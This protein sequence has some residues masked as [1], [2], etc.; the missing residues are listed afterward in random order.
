MGKRSKDKG[1]RGERELVAWLAKHKI[2]AW[3]VIGQAR[4]GHENPD[5]ESDE[6][7]YAIESKRCESHNPLTAH[8]K[9][10]A[11]AEMRGDVRPAIVFSRRNGE[12]VMVTIDGDEFMRLFH[13]AEAFAA[14][15]GARQTMP[16]EA[17]N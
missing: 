4:A 13:A 14:L 15:Q 10:S 2:K 17:A 12:P 8:V 3:R 9:A 16:I 6:L 7:P 1:D 11:E 5:L